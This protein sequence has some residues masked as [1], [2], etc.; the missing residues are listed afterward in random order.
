M[1]IYTCHAPGHLT[2]TLG[3]ETPAEAAE[4]YEEK[5]LPPGKRYIIRVEEFVGRQSGFFEGKKT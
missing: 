4:R 5:F 2:V 1:R 3:A